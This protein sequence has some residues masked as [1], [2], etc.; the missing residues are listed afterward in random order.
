[1]HQDREADTTNVR[2]LV[3]VVKN[4]NPNIQEHVGVY[5]VVTCCIQG[6]LV[7]QQGQSPV[8]EL[9]ATSDN[10]RDHKS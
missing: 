10:S 7:S 9:L 4:I 8:C 5:T 2:K 1:L 3:N 6:C